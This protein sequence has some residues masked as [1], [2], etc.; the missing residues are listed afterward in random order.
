MALEHS[1][2]VHVFEMCA[3]FSAVQW[4]WTEY[5]TMNSYLNELPCLGFPL[6]H[7]SGISVFTLCDEIQ[8][9]QNTNSTNNVIIIILIIYPQWKHC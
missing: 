1:P 7:K 5:T 6:G 4:Q 8:R 3:H 9:N 2:I